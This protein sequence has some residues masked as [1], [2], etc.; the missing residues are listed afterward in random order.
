MNNT[1]T[2]DPIPV[3]KEKDKKPDTYTYHHAIINL[4]Y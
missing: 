3:W 4:Q 1:K 2:E